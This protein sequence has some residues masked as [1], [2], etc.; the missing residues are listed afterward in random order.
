[1]LSAY[2]LLTLTTDCAHTAV[3]YQP[4][5]ATAG[6]ALKLIFAGVSDMRP[7]AQQPTAADHT[8]AANQ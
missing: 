7:T 3:R 1:M 8:W 4:C 2:R 6:L 5:P